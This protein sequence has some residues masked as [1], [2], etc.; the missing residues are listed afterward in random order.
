MPVYSYEKYRL[1]T[2]YDGGVREDGLQIN[3]VNENKRRS[4]KGLTQ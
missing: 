3:Y 2:G 1:F 4:P